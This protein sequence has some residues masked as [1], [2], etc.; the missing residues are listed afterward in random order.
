M[1]NKSKIRYDIILIIGLLAI[2]A[3]IALG[4]RLT[5]KTGKTV[6]VSVDGVEKYTF[7]LDEDLEF[8]IE[9]YEGGTNY[10]VIKDG[11]ACLTEASCPDLLCVH[12][13]KISSQG[14]SIICL[15]NRVVVE[16]R[17]DNESDPKE[18]DAIVG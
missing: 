17:D 15:P 13:G 7:T 18:F 16:I 6:V 14:Q 5:E 9:G 11:E 3:I 1:K 8:K 4:V 12:M 2:T 10:L